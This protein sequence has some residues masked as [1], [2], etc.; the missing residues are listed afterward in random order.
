[1]KKL[2]TSLTLIATGIYSNAISQNDSWIQTEGNGFGSA[3]AGIYSI[4]AFKGS[5]Y[6]GTSVV[7]GSGISAQLWSSTTGN[8]GSFN[9]ITA[10][11]PALTSA[12]Y[13]INSLS[14]DTSAPATIYMGVANRTAGALIYYSTNGSNWSK[15]S[16]RGFGSVKN[17]GLSSNLA[18]FQ[19]TQSSNFVYV[20][21]NDTTTAGAA[22][23][24]RTKYGDTDST[25][26]TKVADF[27]SINLN[28]KNVSC[29]YAWNNE[30]YAS[31]FDTVS[32]LYESTDGVTW[33]KNTGADN[34]FGV[35]GNA[36][37]SSLCAFNGLLFAGTYNSKKGGQLWTTSNGTAWKM[38]NGNAFG[39]G[40][41]IYELRRMIVANGFLWITGT[42]VYDPG[43][44]FGD[45]VWRSLDGS[46][47]TQSNVP[48]YTDPANAR[49]YNCLTAFNGYVYEGIRDTAYGGQIWRTDAGIPQAGFSVNNSVICKG[50]TAKFSDKASLADLYSWFV[51][52][53][54]FSSLAN[55]ILI[56][57]SV[58][59]DTIMQ[60]VYNVSTSLDDTARMI[61]TTKNCS[62]GISEN[63]ILNDF[64]LYPNPADETINV[65]LQYTLTAPA[66]VRIELLD[67]TGKKIKTISET[68]ELPAGIYQTDININYLPAGMYFIHLNNLAQKLII[69]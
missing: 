42:S 51:N 12:D 68:Q 1:M 2:I 18:V 7:S 15:M 65:T 66:P 25:H 35:S 10:F 30:L 13:S 24:W 26:W 40:K 11:I 38:N 27:T 31:V 21:V 47:W 3:K 67:I 17:T 50:D 4:D 8:S 45:L 54:S 39:E 48:G 52:G 41:L 58:G 36:A 57:D 59:P 6:A 16:K 23:I 33:V 55:P 5:I 29:L 9:Q 22:S 37:V 49:G 19:G 60:V 63:K 32:H 53:K 20:G 44:S 43:I 56:L 34:G 46:T 64:N 14:H 62:S 69:Q 28:I 61:L